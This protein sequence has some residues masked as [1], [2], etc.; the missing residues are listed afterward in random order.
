MTPQGQPGQTTDAPPCTIHDSHRGLCAQCT[1]EPPDGRRYIRWLT[2]TVHTSK[3][4]YADFQ[5]RLQRR[6]RRK[7][8]FAVHGTRRTTR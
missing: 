2:G 5:R 8:V 6:S 4:V 7:S 3:V 1:P